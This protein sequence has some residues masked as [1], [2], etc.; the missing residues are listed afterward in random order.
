MYKNGI[1]AEYLARKRRAESAPG[2][3]AKRETRRTGEAW[4]LRFIDGIAWVTTNRLQ[5]ER[6]NV[7]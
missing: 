4:D 2:K 3:P 6:A 5:K 1:P 7:A